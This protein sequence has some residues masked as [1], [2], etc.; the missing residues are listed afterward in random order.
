M[1]TF[2]SQSAYIGRDANIA[3]PV[4]IGKNAEIHNRC[5]M[6]KYSFLNNNAVIYDNTEI[7]RYCSIGRSVE[8]GGAEHPTSFLSSH[9]FQYSTALFK[10]HPDFNF[11]RSISFQGNRKTVLGHDVWI[12]AKAVIRCG[13]NIGTGSVIA[14]MSFV[15]KDVP[16][17]AI[18]G[19]VPAKIIRFRFP[20]HIIAALLESKWWE[21][22]P[23][24]MAPVNF[25]NIEEALKQ[26]QEIKKSI[27]L[28]KTELSEN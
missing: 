7:G 23:K 18:V 26:I 4:S 25:D 27:N 6:G 5:I 11:R 20:Q 3:H 10:G 1:K 15:H 19:G 22:A 28:K 17:Y 16:P 8:V 9:S 21:L 24:Q 13:V 12:G 2:I 14:A